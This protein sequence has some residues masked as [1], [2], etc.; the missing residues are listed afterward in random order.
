MAGTIPCRFTARFRDVDGIRAAA[1]AYGKLLATATVTQAQ[2][3][4]TDWLTAVTGLSAANLV[5][6]GIEILQLTTPVGDTNPGL[7]DSDVI[8]TGVYDFKVPAN[9]RIWGFAVP[10]ISDSLISGGKLS[11]SGGNV[12]AFTALMGTNTN[13]DMYTNDY[14]ALGALLKA[15][16]TGRKRRGVRGS[17]TSVV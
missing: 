1:T 17:S 14:I 10:S 5:G 7:A 3:A 4:L 12:G 15:F 9:G 6:G 11:A 2:T 8:S 13:V 16:R